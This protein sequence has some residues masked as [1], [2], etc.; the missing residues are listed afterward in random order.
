VAER[1]GS[2]PTFFII[3]AAKC[4]TSSLHFYLDQHPEISMSRIKEPSV[5]STPRFSRRWDSHE[6]L[7]DPRA[8]V[9]GEA[10]TS[11]SRYPVEGD[12]A[13]AIHAA[14][15]DAKLIYLIGDPVERAISDYMQLTV[16]GFERRPFAEAVR[17]LPLD[18]PENF[19][20][21]ASRY[22]MQ[23]ER[24][25]EHFDRSALLVIEQTR[26]REERAATLAEVFRFLEVDPGFSSARFAAEIGTRDD[27]PRHYGVEWRLR[28]SRLG[29]AYRRLPVGLRLPVS[30]LRRRVLPRPNLR[31]VVDRALRG[32]LELA[33]EGELG[34][35]LAAAGSGAESRSQAPAAS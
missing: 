1:S 10:S 26:L 22:T 30:S 31:P 5:F 35:A 19:Y 16:T 17:E 25:L 33:L 29:R 14:V 12:A 18:D 28:H 32:E 9:R 7:F 34:A 24:Y 27:H 4:G 6:G 2:D 13:A 3:G 20:L 23:L 8:P 11:Y 15:P 21:C